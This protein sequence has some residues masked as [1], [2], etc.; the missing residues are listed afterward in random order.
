MSFELDSLAVRP[1]TIDLAREGLELMDQRYGPQGA[2][3]RPYHNP[4][5]VIDVIESAYKLARASG[6]SQH[7]I[8]LIIVGAAFH[9]VEQDKGIGENE[10]TSAE[11]ATKAM[12]KHS[13][14]RPVSKGFSLRDQRFVD[15][16]IHGTVWHMY[17]GRLVQHAVSPLA[18]FVADGDLCGLGKDI[19]PAWNNTL[20]LMNEI[21]GEGATIAQ[22]LGFV[23]NSTEIFKGHSYFTSA[24]GFV[25]PHAHRSIEFM[26][27]I[28]ASGEIPPP[29]EIEENIH[30]SD[31]Q[32]SE[33]A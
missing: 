15:D 14:G 32:Q 17:R 31:E 30:I 3:P 1:I 29:F 18:K 20:R 8:E 25:Y 12:N 27:R 16:I 4:N 10:A 6:V 9:D 21:I 23:A 7:G 28:L 33:V 19:K 26:E 5:H 2:S 11:A 24:A 13:K 22:K